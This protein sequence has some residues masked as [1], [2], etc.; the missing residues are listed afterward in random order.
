MPR[1]PSPDSLRFMAANVSGKTHVSFLFFF[2]PGKAH[3]FGVDNDH[4]IARVHMGSEDGFA[5]AAQQ[6]CSFYRDL[7][8]HL[9]LGVDEPPFAGNLAGFGGKSFHTE[10]KS[11]ETT[12]AKSSCQLARLA[13]PA[14]YAT[15]IFHDR[16]FPFN[17]TN[18]DH[19]APG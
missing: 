12:N 10:E 1:P 17:S 18:R 9:V 3:F 14:S 5:F 6:V 15:R 13:T 16:T 19:S 2:F 8:Q 7:A 11:T 4:K